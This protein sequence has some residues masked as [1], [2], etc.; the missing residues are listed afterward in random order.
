[1]KVRE[2]NGITVLTADEGNLLRRI[3]WGKYIGVEEVYLSKSDK[4]E[5]YE[6]LPCEE[7]VEKEPEQMEE[8]Q[9]DINNE[10]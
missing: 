5:Y 3:N 2:E 1:M 6:E 7:F 8:I 9:A 4:E 10:E